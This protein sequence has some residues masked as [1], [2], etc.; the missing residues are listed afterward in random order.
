MKVFGDF[1][2]D[3][4]TRQ[5]RRGSIPV[6]LRGQCL[7]LLALMIA[8]PG[9]LISREE[10]ARTLWP[11]SHVEVDHGLDVLVSRLRTTLGDDPKA[12]RYLETVPRRGYRFVAKVSSDREDA[13]PAGVS[14]TRMLVRYAEVAVL[15]ALLVWAY[16]RTRYQKFVPH[17]G[18]AVQSVQKS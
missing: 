3:E 7:E 4:Q 18:A 15:A 1:E 5:L 17:Q 16:T 6:P 8:R 10:I 2:F 11:D 14:R 13:V 9:E 12:P